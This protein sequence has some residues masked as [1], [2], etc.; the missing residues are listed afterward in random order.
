MR[1]IRLAFAARPFASRTIA[2]SFGL[3]SRT[4]ARTLPIATRRYITSEKAASRSIANFLDWKPESAV[5]DVAVNGF[6]RSVRTMKSRS[7]VALGDGGSLAS[8]QAI[9][10][11]NLAEG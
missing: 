3:Q 10:P 11:T 6:I 5:E 8:L 7:F 1:P 2:A 4:R 9:V